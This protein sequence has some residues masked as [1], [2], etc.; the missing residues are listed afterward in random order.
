MTSDLTC[1]VSELWLYPIKGCAGVR[2]PSATLALT[3]LEH[4]G[5]GDREWVLADAEG[6]FLSQR[7]H[8]LLAL[9]QPRF[10]AS[11]LRLKAP[12]MIDLDLPFDSEGDV[13]RVH[14]WNDEL[15]GVTQGELADTWFSRYLG[16]PCRL[17]RFDPE[18]RR[19]AAARYT[20]AV[21]AP[22]KFADA[23]PL[24]V[25]GQASI[26]E[27]NARLAALGAA[28]V[29][30]RRFRPNLVLEGLPAHE[31]DFVATLAHDELA[32]ECVKPC[33]RCSVPGVDPDTAEPGTTVTDLLAATRATPEG[34]MFGV[35]A[36]V[37][38]GAGALLREG[39]EFV[40]RLRFD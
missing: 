37:T 30:R 24:L 4:E 22:Y 7:S 13:V 32:L 3:G 27:F 26:D 35:N 12:G 17:L 16:T 34:V 15:A 18:Q 11:T 5:I 23:F 9:V 21:A 1:R 19:L 31:E 36:I 10:T 28:P 29:D 2:L 39:D 33:A 20:G 40:G 8:P 14:V 25:L 6:E 38:R